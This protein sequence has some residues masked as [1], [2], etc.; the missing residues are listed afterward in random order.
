MYERII[1]YA[2]IQLERSPDIVTGDRQ[3]SSKAAATLCACALTCR[4]WLRISRICLYQKL[5]LTSE[6]DK[7]T[8]DSLI[9]SLDANRALRELV[10][11]LWVVE[12]RKRDEFR[13]SP[14]A[15]S[16][17]G[18]DYWH[19][20]PALLAGK[21]P[22]LRRLNIHYE[23]NG[24]LALHRACRM[25]LRQFSTIVEL[26][27]QWDAPVPFSSVA[28]FLASFPRLDRLSLDN[29]YYVD[30]ASPSD[31]SHLHAA[32]RAL[33]LIKY[34]RRTWEGLGEF[35]RKSLTDSL[36]REVFKALA[37]SVEIL[38]W[39]G[40]VNTRRYLVVRPRDRNPPQIGFSVCFPK[41][42]IIRLHASLTGDRPLQHLSSWL[43]NLKATCLQNVLLHLGLSSVMSVEHLLLNLTGVYHLDNALHNHHTTLVALTI[44]VLLPYLSMELEAGYPAGSHCEPISVQAARR[45]LA[46]PTTIHLESQLP[47]LARHGQLQV[48][49]CNGHGTPSIWVQAMPD[50][51]IRS[52]RIP[53]PVFTE[54][55]L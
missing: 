27:F 15:L 14:A 31:Q 39:V 43:L 41:L 28:K 8:V 54:L 1:E 34:L 20:W 46:V 6:T 19:S 47:L 17:R 4:A 13:H 16:L 55:D 7:R 22:R 30:H 29:P 44:C 45:A 10:R 26:T 32:L 12:A 33:P 3:I 48:Y 5:R 25:L 42:R 21:L 52:S 18:N 50:G 51:Q 40:N 11:D 36:S 35:P 37:P 23:Y 38:D 24:E 2:C 53:P 9:A 49:I